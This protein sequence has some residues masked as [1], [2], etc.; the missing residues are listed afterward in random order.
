M[1]TTPGDV[2]TRWDF[3]NFVRYLVAN[4][5]ED[6]KGSLEE[7]LRSLYSLL[8][9]HKARQPSW[10]LFAEMVNGALSEPP[11][12]VDPSWMQITSALPTAPMKKTDLPEFD[13]LRVRL[14]YQI[15]DLHRIRDAGMYEKKS[16]AELWLGWD[17]PTGDRW[18]NF[19]PG[20]FLECAAELRGVENTEVCSW[21][22][23]ED[24]LDTG[25]YYE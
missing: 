23:L 10:Q 11:A 4:K 14:R 15:A 20:I 25:Q 9:K 19:F 3:S 7:Y 12:A 16:E 22:D 1:A 24:F 13:S 17:S 6:Y 5:L 18:Y 8:E 21:R 2:K